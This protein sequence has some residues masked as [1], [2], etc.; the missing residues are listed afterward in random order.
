MTFLGRKLH[1]TNEYIPY[2]ENEVRSAIST[3]V[4]SVDRVIEVLK[5]SPGAVVLG[6]VGEDMYMFKVS[7][8]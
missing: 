6:I 7:M 8:K 5:A 3:T 1:T 4:D 2:S